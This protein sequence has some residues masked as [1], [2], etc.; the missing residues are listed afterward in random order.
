MTDQ[1]APTPPGLQRFRH[2]L[3]LLLQRT[4]VTRGPSV[5]PFTV[6]II[7]P[8]DCK[9]LEQLQ[10]DLLAL[11]PGEAKSTDWL[12]LGD[13]FAAAGLFPQARDSHQRAVA[14]ARQE[15][16]SAAEAEAQFKAFRA[17]C[18]LGQWPEALAAYNAAITLRPQEYDLFD[19]GRYELVSILGAGGFGTV[20]HCRDTL[21]GQ[22]DVAIKALHADDLTRSIEDLFAEARTLKQ[23]QKPGEDLAL[24]GL[25]HW[26]FVDTRQR[27]GPYLVLEYFPG[28]S[29]EAYLREHGTLSAPD[30]LRVALPVAR[31]MRA[32]HTAGVLHRDLKPSNLLVRKTPTG[33]EVRVIDFGLAVPLPRA[34]FSRAVPSGQRSLRDQAFAGTLRYAPPE[35]RGERSDPVREY[36][37]V[38]SFGKTLLEALL[39]DVEAVDE[40]WERLPPDFRD[41][42][43][44]LIQRCVV[45]APGRRFPD[46][47]PIVQELETLDPNNQV[48]RQAESRRREDQLTENARRW[49][50]SPEPRAWVEAHRGQ[51]NHAD[52]LQLLAGLRISP[53]WPMR[54]EDIGRILESARTARDAELRRQAAE[55]EALRR[56][57]EAEQEQQRQLAAQRQR[58]EAERQRQEAERQR[59]SQLE[60]QR[61][62]EQA[63]REQ[64]AAEQQRA[65]A[66]AEKRRQEAAV[67]AQRRQREAEAEYLRAEKQ[68]RAAEERE[69]ERELLALRNRLLGDPYNP[70]LRQTYLAARTPSFV[71]K[72]RGWFRWGEL[73]V[74]AAQ[75]SLG[76]VVAASTGGYFAGMVVG[77][78][79]GV[80]LLIVSFNPPSAPGMMVMTI[81]WLCIGALIITGLGALIAMAFSTEDQAAEARDDFNRW[82]FESIGEF[83]SKLQPKLQETGMLMGLGSVALIFFFGPVVLIVMLIMG[84]VLAAACAGIGI[85]IGSVVL[86][87]L[88]C[89]VGG[90]VG[91]VLGGLIGVLAGLVAGAVRGG[92]RAVLLRGLGAELG[93]LPD[94]VVRNPADA[95][96]RL[97]SGSGY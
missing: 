33:W 19:A 93:P 24:I 89:V 74:C 5:R 23:L 79:L 21:A 69:Q 59:Q 61:Q 15:Q 85:A 88:S 30:L 22:R 86:A 20:F 47:G 80:A 94:D 51:W 75:D 35:Q 60:A 1:Q 54:E 36:S 78:I 43:K 53:F 18:E 11:E 97:L 95:H 40:D 49:E 65:A 7:A 31:A 90:V 13:G 26:G 83:W 96:R 29:L 72:D 45:P 10:T 81:S 77:G 63:A 92:A 6:S 66:E 55:A 32:A 8:G 44:R 12:A 27:R 56:R 71:A 39:G 73:F 58:E 41:P 76:R 64:Q 46:F 4:R 38:Y 25:E 70:H 57:Q 17:A 16:D 82:V 52:W 3:N 67:E 87:L 34:Q 62:R 28:L 14:S 50:A 48:A 9:E 68:R 91:L 2:T 42:L 37:D 84:A